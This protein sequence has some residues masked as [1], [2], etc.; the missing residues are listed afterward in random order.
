LWAY[1]LHLYSRS[2][3][4]RVVITYLSDDA[5]VLAVLLLAVIIITIIIIIIII[6]TERV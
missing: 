5:T 1:F 6:K 2:Y 4:A 3:T